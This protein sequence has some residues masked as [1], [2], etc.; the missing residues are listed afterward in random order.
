VSVEAGE[1]VATEIAAKTNVGLRILR[2]LRSGTE[3]EFNLES[4]DESS[5]NL[6]ILTSDQTE[7]PVGSDLQTLEKLL[8]SELA[9][10]IEAEFGSMASQAI[11]AVVRDR[12]RIENR[13]LI[14]GGRGLVQFGW[15]W[16]THIWVVEEQRGQGQMAKLLSGLEGEARKRGLAGVAIDTFSEKVAFRYERCGYIRAGFIPGF[17]A[18]H[19][20]RHYLYRHL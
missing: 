4:M 14:A 12:S 10:E 11:L 8:R 7:N 5:S 16:V 3:L 17:P 6:E 18:G 2:V 15:L 1:L 13:G 19:P 9:S 20:G